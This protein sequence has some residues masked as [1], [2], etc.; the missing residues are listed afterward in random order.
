MDGTRSAGPH[1]GIVK[2]CERRAVIARTRRLTRVFKVDIETR[3]VCVGS[4]KAIACL[5]RLVVIDAPA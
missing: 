2:R 5:E 3:Y 4:V 1:L